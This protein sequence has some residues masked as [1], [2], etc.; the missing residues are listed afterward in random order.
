[1]VAISF[2]YTVF[3]DLFELICFPIHTFPS[4]FFSLSLSF[5]EVFFFSLIFKIAYASI[6]LASYKLS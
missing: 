5:C 6:F 4:I 2:M 3:Q 1:M